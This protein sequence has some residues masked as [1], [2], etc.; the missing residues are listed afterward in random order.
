MWAKEPYQRHAGS[1]SKADSAAC[2][3]RRSL[4]FRFHD[5]GTAGPQTHHLHTSWWSMLLGLD[6]LHCLGKRS[7]EQICYGQ[8]QIPDQFQTEVWEKRTWRFSLNPINTTNPPPPSCLFTVNSPF[9]AFGIICILVYTLLNPSFQIICG[10]CGRAVHG[11]V[12]IGHL[13]IPIMSIWINL[14]RADKLC[15]ICKSRN[16]MLEFGCVNIKNKDN[17]PPPKKRSSLSYCPLRYLSTVVGG[18]CKPQG[19][20]HLYIFIWRKRAAEKPIY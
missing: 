8:R 18:I 20:V 15:R 7:K 17:A 1:R 10:P 12:R 14:Q 9:Q 6:M 4:K 3:K 2:H 16:I 11:D 13:R 19:L 5:S